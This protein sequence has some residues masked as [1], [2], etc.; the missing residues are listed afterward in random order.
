MLYNNVNQVDV[1]NQM[2]TR[3]MNCGM[4]HICETITHVLDGI[5]LFGME[6]VQ[7][8]ERPNRDGKLLATSAEMGMALYSTASFANRWAARQAMAEMDID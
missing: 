5:E 4:Y 2:S 6:I 1:A 7:T 8:N 3:K